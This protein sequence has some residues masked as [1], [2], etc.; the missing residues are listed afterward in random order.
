MKVRLA[1]LLLAAVVGCKPSTSIVVGSKNFTEQQLLGELLAQVLE[2]SGAQVTRRLGLGGTFVCDQAIRNGDIDVYVEYTGTALTAIL[3]QP[4]VRD[5]A[6]ALEQ[7]RAAYAPLGIE[8]TEPLGFDNSFALVIRGEDAKQL[9]IRTISDAVPHAAEWRAGFGYEFRQRQD[10]YPGL[11]KTYGMLF[12]FVRLMDLGLLYPALHENQVD[13]VAGNATD[14]QI[15]AFG[16]VI[17][18]DDKHYFPPYEAVPIVR[19]QMLDSRIELRD[20]VAKLAGRI[21]AATMSKLNF[22]IDGQHG[23]F[24]EVIRKF[25]KEAGL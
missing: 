6:V 10:G 5:A 19:K 13:I 25:R 18:Q 11:H 15:G 24:G 12:K 23:D 21:D 1:V 17:L 9:N 16:M 7:V 2:S 4:P 8:W 22:E 3:K 14:A 20:M